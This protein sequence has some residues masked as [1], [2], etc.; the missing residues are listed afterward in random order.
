MYEIN[1]EYTPPLIE[2][3]PMPQAIEVVPVYNIFYS[4]LDLNFYIEIQPI[5]P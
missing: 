1:I 3:F 5:M 2:P 4:D